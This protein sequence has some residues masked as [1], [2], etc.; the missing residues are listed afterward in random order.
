MRVYEKV[1]NY[2]ADNGYELVSVAEKIGMI[3]VSPEVFIEVTHNKWEERERNM[4]KK[5]VGM[6][7][8][9]TMT[10]LLVGCGSSNKPS[11]GSDILNSTT[12]NGVVGDITGDPVTPYEPGASGPTNSQVETP[13]PEKNV[14]T[15]MS[16]D[17][18][19]VVYELN[20]PAGYTIIS[21]TKSNHLKL[22]KD[23]N[24]YIIIEIYTGVNEEIELGKAEPGIVYK[25]YP[26]QYNLNTKEVD[27]TF[28]SDDETYPTSCALYFDDEWS[29]NEEIPL[30]SNK[31]YTIKVTG[32]FNEKE[33]D[34]N[35]K[36]YMDQ[37]PDVRSKVEKHIKDSSNS[38][39]YTKFVEKLF[40]SNPDIYM[41]WKN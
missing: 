25:I 3:N 29:Q 19:E 6:L 37:Y 31:M 7:C 22:T 15:L 9:M 17:G 34:K 24:N 11:D 10:V 32:I 36:Y 5:I 33:F 20:I 18:K 16:S 8:A 12:G 21:D 23:D 26:K 14:M 35:H 41:P 39:N 13:T 38:F 30:P 27:I 1:R 40:E 2:I 4:K 28:H